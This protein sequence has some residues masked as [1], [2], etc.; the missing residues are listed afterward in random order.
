MR[1]M[2]SMPLWLTLGAVCGTL[3]LVW[4]SSTLR[5]APPASNPRSIDSGEKVTLTYPDGTKKAVGFEGQSG[6]YGPWIYWYEN[7]RTSH[8]VTY[9]DGNPVGPWWYW[10]PDGREL[11]TLAVEAFWTEERKTARNAQG[12]FETSQMVKQGLRSRGSKGVRNGKRQGLWVRWDDVPMGGE[13]TAGNKFCEGFFEDG[14][15]TGLWTFWHQNGQ[16]SHEGE[17]K[18][19]KEDGAWNFWHENGHLDSER[20]YQNGKAEGPGSAWHR[21]GQKRSE[22]AFQDGKEEGPWIYWFASV[23]ESGHGTSRVGA[24]VD[25]KEQG[26]WTIWHENGRLKE[27][28]EF[29]NGEKEGPWIAWFPNG[30][31][32]H[33]GEYTQGNEEGHWYFWNMDGEEY[34]EG[35]FRNGKAVGPRGE[36]VQ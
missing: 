19:G 27:A 22:G 5:V 30:K 21:N 7:G 34:W 24:Y 16:K 2:K 23:E 35:Q 12:L 14:E 3:A 31:K 18:D 32:W 17:F 10:S 28:G 26:P 11:G 6:K 9:A 33:E 4:S 36:K 15:E 8:E 13:A 29:E 1:E 20:V 25:G